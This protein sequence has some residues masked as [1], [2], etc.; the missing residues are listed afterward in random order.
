MIRS[1][2]L[3]DY[4]KFRCAKVVIFVDVTDAARSYDM[5]GR[6][7]DAVSRLA[8]LF[9][10]RV[11]LVEQGRLEAEQIIE[12]GISDAWILLVADGRNRSM[13]TKRNPQ[14]INL[15]TQ[16]DWEYHAYREILRQV[17]ETTR[18]MEDV[19]AYYSRFGRTG[20]TAT[21]AHPRTNPI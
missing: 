20:E 11:L 16:T 13:T 7:S 9:D 18:I 2:S 19:T 4:E 8:K 17:R 3:V 6:H 14:R 21:K 15:D 12:E 10:A 1:Q 5:I